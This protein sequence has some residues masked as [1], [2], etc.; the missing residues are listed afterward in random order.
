VVGSPTSV[1]C[2]RESCGDFVPEDEAF[3]DSGMYSGVQ[4]RRIADPAIAK[5]RVHGC[6]VEIG[7][8]D[9]AWA[10]GICDGFGIRELR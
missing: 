3:F 8:S 4:V 1:L 7:P 6:Q 10:G 5:G 9:R 2:A